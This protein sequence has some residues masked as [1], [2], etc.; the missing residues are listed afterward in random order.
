MA[1][2][3][4]FSRFFVLTCW[5][6]KEIKTILVIKWLFNGNSIIWGGMRFGKSQSSPTS[7]SHLRDADTLGKRTF[8]AILI[9][10]HV[11]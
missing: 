4:L 7:F 8:T 11:V 9:L 1:P 6:S 5:V 2:V 10:M 3:K